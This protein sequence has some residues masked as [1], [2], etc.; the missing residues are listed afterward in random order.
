MPPAPSIAD[1]ARQSDV[2]QLVGASASWID[3][4]LRAWSDDDFSKV[5]LLAPLAVELLGK[6]V[7]WNANPVLVLPLSEGHDDLLHNLATKPRLS[8]PKLR[9]VGLAVLLRRLESVVSGGLSLDKKQRSRMV[10]VRNGAVHVGVPAQSR[11][12][13]VD[14]L[15]V[16]NRMLDNLGRDP[17]LFYRNHFGS[18]QELLDQKRSEA[19]HQVA[20]KRARARLHLSEIE[21]RLGGDMFSEV[22]SMLEDNAHDLDQDHLVSSNWAVDALC[23]E[24]GS[25]GRLQGPIDLDANLDLDVSGFQDGDYA[26]SIFQWGWNITL[27]PTSFACNVCRLTLNGSQELEEC[28]LPSSRH[29]IDIDDLGEEFDPDLEVER[30]YG[31]RD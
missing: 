4:A 29:P 28:S 6:A 3:A 26:A 22:T 18:V 9:T 2:S 5:A 1:I 30:L 13:L 19:G 7:L 8:D 14:S 25:R 24:C 15:G 31:F 23:P 21:E 27:T 20:A 11:H 17:K 10:H 12:V 16:C